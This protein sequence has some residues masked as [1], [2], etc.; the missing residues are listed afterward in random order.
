MVGV[1]QE[2]SPLFYTNLLLYEALVS[3]HIS[4]N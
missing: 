1:C 4:G 3:I 2:V